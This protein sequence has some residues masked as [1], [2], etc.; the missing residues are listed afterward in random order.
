MISLIKRMMTAGFPVRAGVLRRMLFCLA[1]PPAFFFLALVPAWS[2]DLAVYSGSVRDPQGNPLAGVVISCREEQEAMATTAAAGTFALLLPAALPQFTLSVSKDGYYPRF[3]TFAA[4]SWGKSIRVITL[5]PLPPDTEA[6]PPAAVIK[7]PPGSPVHIEAD[8]LSY[9]QDLNT[10]QADG[11]VVIRYEQGVLTAA[12][13]TLNKTTDEAFAHEQVVLK[14]KGDIL[15]GDRMKIHLPSQTGNVERGKIFIAQ[16]HFYVQGDRIEKRGE[17]TYFVENARATTCDGENPDW[18][19]AGKS[20][21]VTVDGYGTLTHGRV[22]AGK[23]PVIYTPFLLFP[24]KTT[25]QSG[26]LFPHRMAYSQDKLGWDVG[27]PFFWAIS[28]DSDATFYQRYMSQRGFQEGAELRFATASTTGVVYGDFL[29]DSKKVTETVGNLNRDWQTNQSRWSFYWS[30]ETRFDPTFYFRAD[31]AKVSDN[32]YFRDFTSYNYFLANYSPEQKNPFKKVSFVGD[33]ALTSLDSNLRLV[34]NWKLF[35]LTARVRDTRDLTVAANDGTLQQYPEIILA[36]AKA[37]LLGTPVN[38]EFTS[39]YDYF[40]RGLGQKGHYLDIN[41][42]LSLPLTV[43][44]YFQITPFG[45]VQGTFWW[46]DDNV[47]DGLAKNGNRGIYRAGATMTSEVSRVFQIDGTTLSRVRHGIKP[48]VTYTYVP[49]AQQDNLPNFIPTVAP[50]NTITSTPVYT[51]AV[52]EQNTLTY[53]LTNTLIARLLDK[54]GKATYLEFLRFKLAQTYDLKAASADSAAAGTERRPFG[55]ISL[56]LD[57]KPFKYLNFSSRNFYN[58]YSLNWSQANYDLGMNDGR[59]D[60]ANVIYRYTQNSLEEVNLLLK[61]SVAKGL[62]FTITFK[63]DLLN[64]K[65]IEQT[66]GFNFRRQCWHVGFSY[67]DRDNDKVYEF[68]FGIYGM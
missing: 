7:P 60:T 30:Q 67:G 42:T 10:Y 58:V 35:N 51:A 15:E 61:A 13:V 36:G 54:D 21:N 44:D 57:F 50:Q 26:F 68:R 3:E 28:K 63:K 38:Y 5:F 65:N 43:G 29:N 45:G 47:E 1:L 8:T 19:L 24:A 40:Y 2:S 34:K 66:Y 12:T 18:C 6:L 59:G 37:P 56:E 16:T 46:R 20:L 17:A 14:S 48:E 33:E 41:P 49:Y 9:F 55:D 32:W 31:V 25:R 52:P 27:I 62:D 64:E 4:S 39:T 11:N 23:L 53:A 22:Y